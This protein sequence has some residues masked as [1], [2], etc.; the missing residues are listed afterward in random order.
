MRTRI[1]PVVTL[2]AMG[3]VHLAKP[4]A[5]PAA[6]LSLFME[7]IHVLD[8]VFG[9]GAARPAI[10][11]EHHTQNFVLGLLVPQSAGLGPC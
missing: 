1:L 11:V 9:S 7:A 5:D 8:Q 2:L 4:A 6:A 3:C 10:R